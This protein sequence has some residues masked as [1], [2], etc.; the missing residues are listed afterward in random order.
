MKKLFLLFLLGIIACDQ[1]DIDES[2]TPERFLS[3]ITTD[4]KIEKVFNT[5]LQKNVYDII[6]GDQLVFAYIHAGAECD[7]I[8]DDEWG[9]QLLFEIDPG[10]SEFDLTDNEILT[11]NCFYNQFGAWVSHEQIEVNKGRI[12]GVKISE[13][14]WDINVSVEVTSSISNTP[15]LIEFSRIYTVLVLVD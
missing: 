3:T 14:Q 5:E 15:K 9:E 12:Q 4:L 7:D 8:L 2:C 13:T 11:T 10:V 6:N 1:N